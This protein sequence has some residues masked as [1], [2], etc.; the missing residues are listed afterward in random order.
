M[1]EKPEIT[2]KTIN[3]DTTESHLSSMDL[4]LHWG[5]K[6]RITKKYF[7]NKTGTIDKYDWVT[8]NYFVTMD[9]S[10]RI[11][12]FHRSE[13]EL[14]EDTDLEPDETQQS[15]SGK[16]LISDSL[17]ETISDIKGLFDGGKSKEPEDKE[18]ITDFKRKAHY[19]T[20]KKG[21]K[22]KVKGTTVHKK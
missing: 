11:L 15:G 5:Q 3:S 2:D 14:I 17:K 9:N 18:P 20:N 19:R 1:N 12:P 22:Y 6:V 7:D 10:G 4:W 13:F 21:E 16:N 8:G